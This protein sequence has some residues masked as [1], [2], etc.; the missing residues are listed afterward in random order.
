MFVFLVSVPF[1]QSPNISD[2]LERYALMFQGPFRQHDTE[3]WIHVCYSG[4]EY[5]V[6]HSLSFLALTFYSKTQTI[7]EFFHVTRFHAA[8]WIHR[9]STHFAF[10]ILFEPVHVAQHLSRDENS[11]L[12]AS[13]SH[14]QF[15]LEWVILFIGW[16]HRA[17]PNWS[18]FFNSSFLN[19]RSHTP[20]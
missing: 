15:Q 5:V 16:R 4:A 13:F 10:D 20:S 9:P 12:C 18:C 2:R 6:Q 14:W 7:H 3:W 1:G 8:L 17:V 11:L 19:L